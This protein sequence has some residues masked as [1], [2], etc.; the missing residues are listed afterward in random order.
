[1]F[2]PELA[3]TISG[4]DPQSFDYLSNVEDEHFWFVTRNRLIAGLTDKFFPDARSFLEI[5]CG[6]GFVLNGISRS[7]PWQRIVGTELHPAG[8]AHARR[9]LPDVEF[10]QIDA[11]KMPASGEFDLVGAFDVVEHIADDKGALAGMRD[12]VKPGGGVIVTVPQHPWLWS[13]ADD[14]AHHQRRYVRGELEAKLA[15]VGFEILF[16]SSFVFSLLPLMT[17]SRINARRRRDRTGDDPSIT[18][19]MAPPPFVNRMLTSI[20][21]WEIKLALGGLSWPVGGSRVVVAKAI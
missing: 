9:R 1:M 4:F 18:R 17:L 8:L 5:G 6:T 7:R 3:D 21:G 14:I 16:T 12:A 15:D 10:A 20:L 2:A 19:E 11:R 13:L